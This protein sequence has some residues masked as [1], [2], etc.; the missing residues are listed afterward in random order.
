M[1]IRIT[2]NTYIFFNKHQQSVPQ[3]SICILGNG[4]F[5]VSWQLI[6]PLDDCSDI[7]AIA[8]S[9]VFCIVFSGPLFSFHYLSMIIRITL[10]TYIF[11]NKHQQ[12]V[13]NGTHLKL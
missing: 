11:F 3:I 8:Q 2:L 12:S 6:F 9:S 7:R 4:V 10:N 1:I 13:P 5:F